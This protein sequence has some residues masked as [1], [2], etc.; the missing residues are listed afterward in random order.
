M[1]AGRTGKQLGAVS[2]DPP[3][4]YMDACCLNRPFD[5]QAQHRVRLEAAAVL[6]LLSLAEAGSVEWVGSEVIQWEIS[7]N[8]DPHKG[9]RVAALAGQATTI[10]RVGPS[11]QERARELEQAGLTAYDALHL[12]CAEAAGVDVFP[13]TDDRLLRKSARPDVGTRVRTCNPLSWLEEVLADG[14]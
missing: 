3:R 8:P 7:L 14:E 6:V 4:V 13:T 10:V 2:G 12:A 1:S 11:E 9:A 5:D